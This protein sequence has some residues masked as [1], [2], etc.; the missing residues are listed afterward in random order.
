VNPSEL[1]FTSAAAAAAAAYSW[2][3]KRHVG[4]PRARVQNGTY[5]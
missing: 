4:R 2:V 1:R 5:R 3:T